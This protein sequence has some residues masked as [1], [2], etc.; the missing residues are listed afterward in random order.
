M[1][2]PSWGFCPGRGPQSEGGIP[3]MIPEGQQEIVQNQTVERSYNQTRLQFTLQVEVDEV[4]ELNQTAIR[5][6]VALMLAVNVHSI[7]LQL[8]LPPPSPPPPSA[9]PPSPPLPSAPP[10]QPPPSMPPVLPSDVPQRPPPPSPPPPL[11]PPPLKPPSL[12]PAPHPPSLPP[13]PPPS[14]PPPSPPAPSSP[15]SQL[16]PSLP[17]PV[18]PP[19]SSPPPASPA[20]SR[21]RRLEIMAPR[22]RRRLS[23]FMELTITID[24]SGEALAS[25]YNAT[26]F[27]A[28][29]RNLS[30]SLPAIAAGVNVTRASPPTIATFT[31]YQN[32]TVLVPT[33]VD[34]APGFKGANGKCL[35][36][37]KGTYKPANSETSDDG[38]CT[39]CSAGRYQSEANATG[40]LLCER[41]SYCDEGAAAPLP[42]DAGSYS[43]NA[44]GLTSID[45]CF[46]CPE[47]AFC[48]AGSIEP[49]NCSQGTFAAFPRTQLCEACQAGSYQ[50][51]EGATACL[52]CGSGAFC[53][54]GSSA[55]MACPAGRFSRRVGLQTAEDC[56]ICPPGTA[57]R[58]GA[59]QPTNCSAGSFSNTTGLGNCEPCPAGR[60]QDTEGGT[61]C[62]ECRDGHYCMEGAPAASP[63][64]S[65]RYHNSTLR[66][67]GVPLTSVTG[68][69]ECSAG[70]APP[71]PPC[72]LPRPAQLPPPCSAAP[73]L[74]YSRRQLLEIAG[75]S[76]T[77][78]SIQQA[79]CAAGSVQPRRGQPSCTGCEELC[80]DNLPC[81]YYQPLAGQ[82]MCHRCGGARQSSSNHDVA[83]LQFSTCSHTPCALQL[84]TT[85]QT[86]FRV[87][88]A[89]RTST[90]R[91]AH[92]LARAAQRGSRRCTWAWARPSLAVA[93]RAGPSVA[94]ILAHTRKPSSRARGRSRKWRPPSA[95]TILSLMTTTF[96]GT[97]V[98]TPWR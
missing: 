80:V 37:A 27:P 95:G 76:C 65:G 77:T 7:T 78:G 11:Q 10:A 44:T 91:Q 90:A 79:A 62:F 50:S 75:H 69:V 4:N 72:H 14:P 6:Q 97:T 89:R 63:C 22:L 54:S 48:P 47:G 25:S 66:Q 94:A 13:S 55:E 29:W 24:L 5:M 32:A 58:A 16:P 51:G 98:G 46:E 74:P 68:C 67:L 41:G 39:P 71:Q 88:T 87:S 38:E 36:C 9:P 57:C 42:C 85:R 64:P 60:F 18:A 33:I 84:E 12:P 19:P 49:K 20:G 43:G 21:R 92:L 28:Q 73:A 59:H 35:P 86:S 70:Q 15:T 31:R 61:D 3:I 2:C 40:C 17:E 93:P 52:G 83:G 45:S 8:N 23:S 1:V 30:T 81:G 96:V 82:T 26:A 53:P 34:C 56:E